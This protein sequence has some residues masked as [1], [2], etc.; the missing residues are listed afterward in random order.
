[1][2]KQQ[3]SERQQKIDQIR[4]KQASTESRRGYMI[5]GVCVLVAL[6]IVGAA[7]YQPIKNR[8]DM[9]EFEALDVAEIGV[10]ASECSEVRTEPAEGNQQH[11]E[12][13]TPLDYPE[14]PPAFG[15][16]YDIWADF[17]TKFYTE[18]D[19]PPLGELVHNLEH[20]YTILWYDETAAD[21]PEMMDQIRG[22]ASKFTGGS[23]LRLKFKAVPWT[24]EDGGEFPDGQHIALTHWSVGGAGETDES[25]Q[26]GVWQYCSAPS[27][28]ALETFMEDY[29]YLDSTE[30]NAV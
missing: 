9:G 15:R 20:G 19:R 29:P 1:V 4:K 5:V 28:E 24:S 21:D 13:G 3:K 17:E 6:L 30:P 7:A 23:N 14:A 10:P 12:P 25:K 26:V 22:L 11:V 18:G 27:G 2:A 16:H 8:L